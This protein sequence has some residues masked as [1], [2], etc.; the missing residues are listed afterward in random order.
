MYLLL[1]L[2]MHYLNLRYWSVLENRTETSHVLYLNIAMQH[3]V[4]QNEVQGIPAFSDRWSG[5]IL[6]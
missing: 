4:N 1:Y 6:V 2:R 3:V 5:S